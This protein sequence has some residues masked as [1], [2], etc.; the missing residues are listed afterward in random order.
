MEHA[1]GLDAS[2]SPRCALSAE[3]DGA[4]KVTLSTHSDVGAGKLSPADISQLA[5]ALEADE[6]YVVKVR[7]GGGSP[8]ITSTKAVSARR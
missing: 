8:T 4:G 2:F 7:A 5:A 6:L 3:V 1:F